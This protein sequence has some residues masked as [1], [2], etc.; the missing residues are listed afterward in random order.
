MRDFGAARSGMARAAAATG[1]DYSPAKEKIPTP[2]LE[3]T[4]DVSQLLQILSHDQISEEMR[5]HRVVPNGISDERITP[6]HE[7]RQHERLHPGR[8]CH[9]PHLFGRRV[10][11]QHVRLQARR[12]GLR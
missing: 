10:R 9:F 5:P 2:L 7:M 11:R 8:G 4:L 3:W 1:R 6:W 12:I